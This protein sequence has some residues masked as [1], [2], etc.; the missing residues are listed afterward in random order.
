MTEVNKIE[1]KEETCNCICKSK[2]FQNFLVV[3]TGTFIGAFCALSLF[4][5]LNKPPMPVP[6]PVGGP[7]MRPPMAQP[8]HIDRHH[9]IHRSGFHKSM[10]HKKFHKKPPVKMDKEMQK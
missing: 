7:Q 8:Y 3:A 2:G 1:V 9:K 6:Y 5:A 4:A 10:E